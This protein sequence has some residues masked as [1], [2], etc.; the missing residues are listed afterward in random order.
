MKKLDKYILK[1][2]LGPF[3]LTFSI[4]LFIL[5]MQFLW[6]YIDELVGKGLSL[7]VIFEFMAWGSATLLPMVLPLATLL[8][9]IMTLGGMGENNE[10]LAIKSAG[11]SLS[12]VLRPLIFV[13]VAI[14]IGAFFISN[15]LIPVAYKKIY[16]LRDDIGRTKEVIKIPTGIFYD[17]I[18]GY[19]L[20]V[21]SSDEETGLMHD[22][23]VYDHTS[24]AGNTSLTVA[25]SGLI[26][27]SD[28]GA[29]IVFKMYNGTSYQENNVF[30]SRDT[31]LE[32]NIISFDEQQMIVSR[33]DYSFER[34]DDERFG[35]EIMAKDLK[36]LTHDVDS[37]TTEFAEVRPANARRFTY[38]TS[39]KYM[40]QIDS[41]LVMYKNLGEA[42]GW[43]YKDYRD[44]VFTT[45]SARDLELTQ[46]AIENVASQKAALEEYDRNTYRYVSPIR[47]MTIEQYR[48]FTLSLA[49]LLF[50]FIGAPL[51]SILRKG[52]LGA[53]VIISSFIFLLYWV[54]DISG[55]KLA[56]DGAV[57]PFEGSFISSAVLFP[58]GMYLLWAAIS[59]K[60]FD[61]SMFK[62]RF[63][64]LFKKIGKMV[65]KATNVF[66]KNR[67]VIKVVYMGTPE[68][69]VGPLKALMESEYEIAA[70]VTVPDKPS[71]RGL[72]VSE[73]AVKQFAVEKG[74]KLLQ[75][76]SLKDPEFL[77]QLKALDA[78]MFVVVAFRMLPKE[79]WHMPRLGTFNLHASLLPRYRGAAPINW[80]IINGEKQTG[81][82]TFLIDEQIDTGRILFAE[83]CLIEEYDTFGSL[84]EKLCTMG[85]ALVVKTAD[86]LSR[87]KAKPQE[88]DS[89]ARILPAPK[90]TK[91]TCRIDWS[92]E[93]YNIVNLVRGLAPAPAAFTGLLNNGVETTMKIFEAYVYMDDAPAAPGTIY[94]DGKTYLGVACGNYTVR[95]LD[96]Q[97]AGKKRMDIADFLRGFRPGEDCKFV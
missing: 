4:V 87:G 41:A 59:E 24:G 91:E 83:P 70:V 69:A 46:N 47:K 30:K 75:P 14:S 53:P 7:G 56:R 72:K 42:P 37:L 55:K 6:L 25:D 71:G 58:V 74:L 8:A 36:T 78:D 11:I 44:S 52:G 19:M 34:S 73:S 60:A 45:S 84:S 79:V 81:V 82:T 48:K 77:A 21:N 35:N 20:R 92:Q 23:L 57:T 89:F 94:T 27:V 67:G 28:D 43:N 64:Q 96:V 10:L 9:S 1:S 68:F 22:I 40:N 3:A 88:Q 31:T 15:D 66:R 54:I 76:V 61:F 63:S 17:G 18:E 12:R 62:Y 50:F 85:S 80:A 5:V 90:I 32:Q 16:A 39:Y 97:L 33:D 13:A 93:G 49:C 95:L 26:R 29:T 86:A 2:F 51:G 38:S 65:R